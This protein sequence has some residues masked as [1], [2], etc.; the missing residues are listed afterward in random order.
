MAQTIAPFGSWRSPITSD[1]IVAGV[2]GLS[3]IQLDG[4]DTCWIESRPTEAGR[5]VIVRRSPD[6]RLID[7]N[8]PPFNA[9]TTVHEYGGGAYL[10]AGGSVFFSNFADQRLYRID[11]GTVARPITPPLKLRFAD[12][13]IDR[14]RGRLI[15]IQE[16]HRESDA[17][18]MNTIVDIDIDG[19]RDIRTLVSGADFYSSPRLR[20]D[21]ANWHGCRGT[22]RTCRGWELELWVADI[23]PDGSIGA[24]RLIAGG[25]AESI[26]QP[27]WSPDGALHFVSDRTGWWNVYAMRQGGVRSL[28]PMDAEFGQPQ[29]T[30]GLSCYSFISENQIACTFTRQGTWELASL[31][32]E[33]GKLSPLGIAGSDFDYVR[34]DATRVVVRSG[35]PDA[36]LAVAELDIGSGV[37]RVLRASAPTPDAALQSY[38]SVPRPVEFRNEDGQ[39]AYAFLY[40]PKNPAF[41]A[42]AGELS[43]H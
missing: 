20:P 2:I 5:N 8:P 12:A 30:F 9:R 14:P 13:V 3:E 7:L 33:T 43:L 22:I 6:G 36:P 11:A 25:A 21:G 37:S 1:L 34:T 27:E 42:P 23:L 38:L 39:A 26:F 10:A 19:A 28:A 16:D 24:A 18:P 15:C 31:D 35:S 4:D 40:E 29:W 41:A 17:N 32:T